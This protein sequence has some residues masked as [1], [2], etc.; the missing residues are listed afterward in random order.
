MKILVLGIGNL[1][2]S[3]DGVGLHVIEAL[4]EENLGDSIDLMEG[5]TGL[6][7]LDAM[8]GYDKII[9]ID[10]I[11]TGNRP[12]KIHTLSPSDLKKKQTVHSFSTHL[13]LD[14][15]TMLELGEKIFPGEKVKEIV[16]LGIEAGD[17]MTISDKCTQAV[18]EAIPAVV[19]K[20]KGYC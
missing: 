6:D 14:F 20:I 5:L 4:R 17:V 8:K 15:L 13:N 10:A 7:L 11:Q 3:D 9:V 1:L 18:A 2:R 16:I 12:G 19:E